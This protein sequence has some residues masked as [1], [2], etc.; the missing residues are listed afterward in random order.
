M[1]GKMKLGCWALGHVQLPGL[2]SSRPSLL[3]RPRLHQAPQTFS[4]CS[5]M[6]GRKGCRAI[7][8]RLP[9]LPFI[10]LPL[11]LEVGGGRDFGDQIH[12]PREFQQLLEA[13]RLQPRCTRALKKS[14]NKR[15]KEV[16][17]CKTQTRD[18]EY[19]KS[20]C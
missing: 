10:A 1:L 4:F 7:R 5:F 6:E 12:K 15:L 13:Q 9:A 20:S 14:E 17:G 3:P 8:Q 19:A 11:N 16:S 2:Q 18:H